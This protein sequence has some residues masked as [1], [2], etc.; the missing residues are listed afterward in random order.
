MVQHI[1]EVEAVFKKTTVIRQSR[2]Q[3]GK[4]SAVFTNKRSQAKV[5]TVY[6]RL[7]LVSTIAPRH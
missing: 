7:S 6:F 1:H 3:I 2:A 5:Y 4:F